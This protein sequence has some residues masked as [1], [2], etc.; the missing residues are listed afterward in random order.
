MKVTYTDASTQT[1]TI[2]T[3]GKPKVKLATDSERIIVL[4][5]AGKRVKVISGYT[6][7]VL[8]N[9]KLRSNTQNTSLVRVWNFYNDKKDEVLVLTRKKHTARLTILQL[10]NNDRF[11]KRDTEVIKPVPK[12]NLLLQRKKKQL[13]VK[14]KSG[15]I[16]GRYQVKRKTGKLKPLSN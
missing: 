5:K 11:M 7:T 15:K 9:K 8:A 10:L 14:L 1:F 3:K 16:L 12:K 2:F 6:G 13:K 4:Q